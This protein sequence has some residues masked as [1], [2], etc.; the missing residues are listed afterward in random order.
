MNRISEG[1]QSAMRILNLHR[2]DTMQLAGGVTY[3]VQGEEKPQI[4]YAGPEPVEEDDNAGWTPYDYV[5]AMA[6]G[7]FVLCFIAAVISFMA[8]LA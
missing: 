2:V 8:V 7:V 1:T 6:I 5:R 4:D 3:M